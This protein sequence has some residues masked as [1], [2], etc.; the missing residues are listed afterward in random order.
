M[1]I[2]NTGYT[3]IQKLNKK[4]VKKETSSPGDE[5]TLGNSKESPDFLKLGKI[6]GE[7][8]ADFGNLNMESIPY[9]IGGAAIAASVVGIS[10]VPAKFTL[11]AA[12]AGAFTG[13]CM[14]NFPIAAKVT[15]VG[16]LIGAGL[17][18]FNASPVGPVVGGLIGGTI[19][20]IAGAIAQD[21]H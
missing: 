9:I 18:A 4:S 19:G 13:G 12:G 15:G 2:Q 20:A 21:A 14:K 5:V 10:G 11:F 16:T 7:K 3:N 6:S 1:K 17:G 8:A